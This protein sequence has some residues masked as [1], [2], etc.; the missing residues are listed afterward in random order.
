MSFAPDTHQKYIWS[1]AKCNGLS[2]FLT[3]THSSFSKFLPLK[4]AVC[5]IFKFKFDL[6]WQTMGKYIIINI[7]HYIA[8]TTHLHLVPVKDYYVMY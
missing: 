2:H 4:I 7:M 1:R 6:D 3:P 5:N 8:H